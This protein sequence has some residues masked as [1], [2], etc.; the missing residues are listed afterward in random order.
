MAVTDCPTD[1]S[2]LPRQ[3]LAE[4]FANELPTSL[5]TNADGSACATDVFSE[6]NRLWTQAIAD[7]ETEVYIDA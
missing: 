5:R 2:P 4:M 7:C 3:L 6:L 1:L